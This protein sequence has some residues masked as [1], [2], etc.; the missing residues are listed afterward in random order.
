M[1]RFWCMIW[2]CTCNIA[3]SVLRYPNVNYIAAANKYWFELT[4]PPNNA[5]KSSRKLCYYKI[6]FIV[7]VMSIVLASGVWHYVAED[8]PVADDGGNLTRTRSAP[9]PGSPAGIRGRPGAVARTSAARR[10]S[11]RSPRGRGDD[12]AESGPPWWSGVR[13]GGPLRKR[14]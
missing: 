7:R 6:S 10:G 9:G 4:W 1:A 2:V 14:S 5:S 13:S 3:L 8:L 12:S 11:L